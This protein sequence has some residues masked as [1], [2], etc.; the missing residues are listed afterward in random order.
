VPG[1][2]DLVAGAGEAIDAVGVGAVVVG[3]ALASLGALDRLRRREADV[4]PRFRLWLGRSI[5]LGLELLVAAD[6]I[7]T[8]ASRPTPSGVGVLAAIVAV[9]TFLSFSLELE[10]TG[11]WPWRRAPVDVPEAVIRR[12]P[13]PPRLRDGSTPS[14]PSEDSS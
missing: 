1:L 14:T 4:Y 2:D 9:R 8:V 5:L 12:T 7:R 3:A 6:I 11:R 10:I 13:R